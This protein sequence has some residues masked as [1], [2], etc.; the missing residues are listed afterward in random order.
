MRRLI[1]AA[2]LVLAAGPAAA[3]HVMGGEMPRTWPQGFLSGLGHPVIGLDHLAALVAVGCIASLLP[4][5]ASAAVVF[6][7]AAIIGVAL[8]LSEMDVPAVEMLVALTVIA[9]GLVAFVGRGTPV[10]AALLFGAAG[11][12]HGHALGES[13]IGAEPAPLYAYL[14]GLAVIQCVLALAVMTAARLLS[15]RV[16]T[17]A[18]VQI[19]GAVIVCFGV[20][21][22][23]QQLAG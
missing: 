21:V 17:R 16:Q 14:A 6:V 1:A 11:L 8:H 3:H 5:G 20:F 9:L 12:I 13:I 4:R 19:A 15:A 22:L 7:G 23:A 10:F 2:I 18:P